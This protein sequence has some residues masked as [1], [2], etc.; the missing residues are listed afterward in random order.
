MQ[1]SQTA[2][3]YKVINCQRTTKSANAYINANKEIQE[4]TSKKQSNLTTR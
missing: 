1:Y 3:K 4:K 2:A